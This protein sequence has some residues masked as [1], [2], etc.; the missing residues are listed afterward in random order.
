MNY[1]CIIIDDEPIAHDVLI[2]YINSIPN[3]TLVFQS[4]NAHDALTY[5]SDHTVDILFLD[6]QMPGLD[7]IGFLQQ[8]VNKPITIMTTANRDHALEG[9]ELGVLDYLV[10]PIKEDRFKLAVMRAIEFLGLLKNNQIVLAK[11]NG[12]INKYLTIKSGTKR[13][14]LETDKITHLQGLKDYSIIYA[15]K[16]KYVIKGYLK[17]I[18]SILPPN[19]F[20]RV[21]KSFFVA[22]KRIK[23]INRNRIEFEGY[24]I[25]I[26]RVYKTAIESLLP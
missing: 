18:E 12:E 19:Y 2:N 10:K 9:F 26:G 24:Q 11:E 7:G 5:L 16:E 21:H 23:I 14:T 25:P 8:L 4:Y 17:N 1:T 3:L 6:V 22:T 13:I 20:T 15:G